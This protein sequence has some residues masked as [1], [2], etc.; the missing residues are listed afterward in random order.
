[1][2]LLTLLT[3]W[4]YADPFVLV[5]TQAVMGERVKRVKRV[6]KKI[7]LA[8]DA[9]STERRGGRVGKGDCSKTAGKCLVYCLGLAGKRQ[10]DV[11]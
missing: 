4:H 1:M 2:T 11:G 5:D 8:A 6:T 10:C 7:K 9:T 3:L